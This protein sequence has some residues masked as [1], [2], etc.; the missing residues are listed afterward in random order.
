MTPLQR[1]IALPEMDHVPVRIGQ[2]LH[3]DVARVRDPPLEEH[4]VV[5]ERRRR[6]LMRRGD[7]RRQVVEIVDGAHPPPSPTRRGLDHQWGPELARRR[8]EGF[9]VTGRAGHDRHPGLLREAAG[10]HLVAE[11]PHRLGRGSHPC[12]AGFDRGLGEARILGQEPVAGM[13]R[14]GARV[15]ARRDEGRRVEVRADRGDEVRELGGRRPA[16]ALGAGHHGA[17]PQLATR[18]DQPDGD[19]TAVR[20]QEPADHDGLRRSRNAA[21]PSRPSAPV[22]ARAIRSGRSSSDSADVA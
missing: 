11:R 1:T 19:L 5:A 6:F 3:L 15:H 17:D 8:D 9:V 20:D 7:R 14:V 10:P 2:D 13:D 18:P 22:R 16:F 4:A 21:T 12:Q